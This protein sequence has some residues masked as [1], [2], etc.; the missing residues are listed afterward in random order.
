MTVEESVSPREVGL[1][2]SRLEAALGLVEHM[3]EG[4]FVPGASTAILRYG[5]LVRLAAFGQRGPA[6]EHPPVKTATIFLVASLTKPVVCAG[7]MLLVQDGKLCLEQPVASLVPEFGQ[8]GKEQVLLRHLF[9]HTSGLP[10]QL[11]ENVEL[12]TRHAPLAD[13]VELICAQELLFPPGA[14]V[15]YQSMGILMLGEIVERITG[16]RLRDFLRQH[17][18]APLG[19]VDTTLGMPHLGMERTALA[20]PS[21]DPNYGDDHMDWGWNSPYWRDLGAPWGGLH[22]TALDLGKFLVH[23]L[24]DAPGPLTVPT[25]QAMTRD[26]IARLPDIPSRERMSNRWGLGWMLGS[27][28]FGDLVSPNTF[29]HTGATGTLFW[30]DPE[31]RLAC[32]LLTNQPR[33]TEFLF[34][35]YSNAVAATFQ[36]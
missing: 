27:A 22:S 11:P 5:K 24:G 6:A 19:M 32:V 23:V 1:S 36:V 30:A 8:R 25:R 31:S 28:N 21:G 2:S 12:R 3:V 14:H 33:R 10:D 29:G 34:P 26:Q 18:F 35:R 17:L 16:Q 15:S 13:F 4:D 7:A 20:L 9:T